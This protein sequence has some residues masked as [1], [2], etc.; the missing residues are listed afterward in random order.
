MC[1][2][3]PPTARPFGTVTFPPSRSAETSRRRTAGFAS[4]TRF[5]SAIRMEA[6]CEWPMKTI[7]RPSL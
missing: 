5:R 2:K 3:S 4:T 7:P 1:S 6:P